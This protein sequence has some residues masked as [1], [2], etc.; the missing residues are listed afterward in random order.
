M[1]SLE[2][3][4]LRRDE[5]DRF[6]E[7]S[8][9]AFGGRP[10]GERIAD[11]ER[12]GRP[13]R[14]VLVLVEDGEIVSQV[15]IYEFGIWFGGVLYP[16]GGLANVATVPEKA[17]RGYAG[18]LLRKTLEWLRNEL[19]CSLCTLYATVHPLYSGLGWALAEDALR[20]SGPPVAFRP[21][22]LLPVDPGGT[23]SR[24]LARREDVDVIEPVYR[25]FVRPR[26]G[27]V[28]RPRW[29]WEDIVL[30][31][32]GVASPRWLALWHGA[33]RAPGGYVT[34]TLEPP[35][36]GGVGES[37]VQVYELVSLRPEGYRALLAFLSAHHLVQTV[38]LHGGRDV[39]WAALVAD[40][41]QLEAQAM[42]HGFMLRIIDVA[43]AIAARAPTAAQVPDIVL[44]IRDEAASW[45]D[46][47]WL[48]GQRDGCWACEPAKHRE[49][50]A[51]IDVASLASLFTG[52]LSVQQ[53]IE[54]GLLQASP[55][56]LATLGALFRTDFPPHS[57]DFF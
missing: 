43:R 55:S 11:F 33:D 47:V 41:H 57:A 37:R 34:Y 50:D 53:A 36:P 42:L 23:I 3:R 16:A 26:S 13:D 32:G 45:N 56:A 46:G 30:R 51:A 12:R 14:N 8:H 22:P 7:L 49:P 52:A 1:S 54:G 40:P 39:P 4:P 21:S 18:L 20:I 2:I 27:Y 17:R 44:R 9:Y 31:L 29:L 6:A 28:E 38:H 10:V 24:R 19:G 15:M 35:T 48:I 5:V 25:A